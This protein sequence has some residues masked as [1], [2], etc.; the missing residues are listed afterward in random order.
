MRREPLNFLRTGYY[1]RSYG[2][3]YGRVT[4]GLW[5]S[6]TAG[7]ATLGRYL[8]TFPTGVFP[9]GNNYRGLGFAVRCVVREG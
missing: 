6:T 1:E 9:Q 5:W 3:I 7:S 8:N 2:Y 4:D